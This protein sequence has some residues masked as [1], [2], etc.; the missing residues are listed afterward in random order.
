MQ[1]EKGRWF[2]GT[3]NV[4]TVLMILGT[5]GSLGLSIVGIYN[6][7]DHRI[8]LL[9]QNDKAQEQHF[10]RIE[11]DQ[12]QM[13]S[14]VKEQLRD[15]A[16]DLRDAKASIGEVHDQLIENSA[17]NRPDTRRWAK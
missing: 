12:S 10:G 7:F 9:E 16:S 8:L 17:G 4:P 2:D 5:A 13:K 11:S 6:S 14:D 1:N 15:I 3:I